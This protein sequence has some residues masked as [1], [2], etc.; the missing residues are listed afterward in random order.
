MYDIFID[1]N[2]LYIFTALDHFQPTLAQP[3]SF[4]KFYF[5]TLIA[6]EVVG[7]NS[8]FQMNAI[9]AADRVLIWNQDESENPL[10][11]MT[12]L[13][14]ETINRKVIKCCGIASVV[15]RFLVFIS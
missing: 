10:F 2:P 5:E 8:I 3:I 11:K 6:Q 7:M 12:N 4:L 14:E 15:F 1:R 13:L 9:G